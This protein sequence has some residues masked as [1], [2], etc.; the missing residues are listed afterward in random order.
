MKALQV[1]GLGP[2]E[3]VL[4]VSQPGPFTSGE[5]KSVRTRLAKGLVLETS[6]TRLKEKIFS[7]FK[8]RQMNN[9]QIHN[10]KK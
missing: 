1:L 10:V 9:R 8:E 5:L 4:S 6:W 3:T 7:L 2:N